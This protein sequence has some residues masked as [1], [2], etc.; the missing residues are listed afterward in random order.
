M[1]REG[2]FSFALPLLLGLLHYLSPKY[3]H[4]E[5]KQWETT[6]SAFPF[7]SGKKKKKKENNKNSGKIVFQNIFAYSSL[8]NQ[9]IHQQP[10]IEYFPSQ[11]E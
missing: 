9:Y 5:K 4:L 10:E 3:W 2:L 6:K 1:T 7:D 11:W 8:L